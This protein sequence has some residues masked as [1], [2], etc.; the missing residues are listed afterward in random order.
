MQKW[1]VVKGNDIKNKAK[2]ASVVFEEWK[3]QN[4]YS[5]IHC[6][7]NM[8]LAVTLPNLVCQSRPK[9]YIYTPNFV[10]IGLFC[11]SVA[12]KNPKFYHFVDFG[13]LWCRQLAAV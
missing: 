2:N 4:K 12:V 6:W 3:M 10:S 1:T 8:F 5:S 9:V 7:R 11:R 13:I